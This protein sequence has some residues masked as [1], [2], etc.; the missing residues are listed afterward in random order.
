M[1]E[2]RWKSNTFALEFLDGNLTSTLRKNYLTNAKFIRIRIE[3]FEKSKNR[4]LTHL[5]HPGHTTDQ[6]KEEY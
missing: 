6:C 1:T 5:I 2:G 3:P 4:G